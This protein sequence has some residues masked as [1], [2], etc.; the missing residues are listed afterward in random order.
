MAAD[1]VLSRAAPNPNVAGA[2]S[3]V[4]LQPLAAGLGSVTSI[5][6]AG[7][8]RLFLTL[9]KG[10]IVVWDGTSL[11]QRP[12]L[13]IS[14]LISCCGDLGLLSAAFHP[15]YSFN[16]FLFVAYTD[17]S[18]NLTIARYQRSTKRSDKADRK[19]GVILLT[20]SYPVDADHHGGQLQFGP[21]GYLYLGVG[22]GG[23]AS[24]IV[25]NGQAD[26]SSL[27]KILRLD[28]DTNAASPPFYT[29][30]PSNPFVGA[31]PPL[32]EVWAKGLRDPWRF[33]FD[34]DTGDL[35][36][37]DV[38]QTA[39]Q[40][41]DFQPHLSRGGENYGWDVM[42][43]SLARTGSGFESTSIASP[44]S[45]KRYRPPMMEYGRSYGDCAVVGGYV[46]RGSEDP[47]LDGV[48]FYGDYCTGRIWAGGF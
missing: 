30:P 40:E 4:A 20:I 22:D 3:D 2:I 12:F 39:R 16:G 19:S 10:Q 11:Q 31:E 45:L 17:K 21:D 25:S 27:G 1:F 42:E 37:G 7:D 46:Y 47:R 24:Q 6:N 35:Y 36:I 29:V 28:V 5:T 41:I 13:D 32:D 8:A 38:G 33:S 26:D 14:G 23:S 44:S 48:Y 43:G 18:G 9:R 15:R 34:R